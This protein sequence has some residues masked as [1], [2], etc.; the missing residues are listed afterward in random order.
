[1]GK[2]GDISPREKA[3]VKALTNTK[4]YSNQE[5][6]RRLEMS[7][8]SIRCIKKKIGLVE[9][10]SPRRKN[11]CGR[12]P[13]FTPRSERFLKRICI[14]NRFATIKEIK[15]QLEEANVNASECTFHRKLKDTDFKACQPERKPKLTATMKAKHLKWAKQWCDKDVD[16]WR[17][18]CFRAESMFEIL[19]NE[20]QYVWCLTGEKFNPNCIIQTV[21]QMWLKA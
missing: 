5:I 16:F 7:E 20:S 15:S 3:E 17:S 14:E 10:L 8:A 18:V 21:K 12:K 1:M 19:S 4:M 6:S 13:I 9:E 2:R 11:K